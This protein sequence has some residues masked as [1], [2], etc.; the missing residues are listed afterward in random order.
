MSVCLFVN[1]KINVS[2]KHF[3]FTNLICL[4]L[5]YILYFALYVGKL[6]QSKVSNNNNWLGLNHKALKL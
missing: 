3:S 1:S 2:D 6:I 5:L 4:Y